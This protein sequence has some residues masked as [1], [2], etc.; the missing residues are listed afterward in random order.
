[1]LDDTQLYGKGIADVF[2]SVS[3]RFGV[4]LLGRDGIDGK[5]TDYRA[6][7]TKIRA[8]RPDVIYYGG[9]TQNNAG[10]LIKDIRSAG[11]TADF[12]GPD[13]ILEQAFLDDGGEDAE[14]VYASFGGVPPTAYEGATLEWSARYKAFAGGEPEPYAVYGYE[15][16]KVALAAIER[17]GVKDR[18]AIRQAVFAT[19]D[20]AGILGTWSFDQYGDTSLTRMSVS[21]ASPSSG[22]L[23]WI[24]QEVLTAPSL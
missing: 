7:A 1:V 12:I 9:I 20:Y 5:A 19:T 8:L 4:R 18:D 11:I 16:A 2:A 10:K 13:G 23:A 24:L 3:Q 17:A 6:I 22:K 15:A 21:K 14:G